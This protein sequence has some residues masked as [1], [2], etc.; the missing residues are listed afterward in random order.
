MD[1]VNLVFVNALKKTT[2]IQ[3]LLS[4]KSKRSPHIANPF[5]RLI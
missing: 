2:V 1:L 4:D 5:G 3:K